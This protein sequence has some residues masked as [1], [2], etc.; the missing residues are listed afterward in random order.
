MG[1]IISIYFDISFI[2]YTFALDN[3]IQSGLFDPP[4]EQE[5]SHGGHLMRKCLT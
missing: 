2:F 1:I 4:T 3:C 5:S